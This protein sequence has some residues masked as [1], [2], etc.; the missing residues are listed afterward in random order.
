MGRS[1][2]GVTFIIFVI[3]MI[4][5]PAAPEPSSM[6]Q[7]NPPIWPSSV[8]VFNPFDKDIG[9]IIAALTVDLNDRILGHF[10]QKRVAFLFS[11]GIYVNESIKVG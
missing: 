1:S 10:S 8:H 9:D 6:V 3:V 7:P 5:F 11:P 2:K 4:V